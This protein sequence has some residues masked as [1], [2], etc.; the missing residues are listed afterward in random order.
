MGAPFSG[1]RPFATTRWTLVAAAGG[2]TSEETSAALA[3]LCETYWYPLYA[4]ARRRG[5]DAHAAQDLTQGFF[6]TVLEKDYLRDADRERGR[7]RSFLLAAFSNYASKQRD[8]A[9]AQKRGGGKTPLSLDF[10]HGESRYCLEPADELTP[11]RIFERRW[12]LT[13][14]DRVVTRVRDELAA[15]GKEQVFDALKGTLTGA[16]VGSYREIGVSLGMSEGA[17]KVA[18]HRLRKRYRACLRAEIAD[19]VADAASNPDAI[20]DEI[21]HLIEAVSG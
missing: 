13:L 20:D 6:A 19:T 4:F 8:H 7:F 10:E 2:D 18:A 12:A 17:V 5:N 1:P 9:A 11:E 15:S 16:P 14:L 3:T 21:R